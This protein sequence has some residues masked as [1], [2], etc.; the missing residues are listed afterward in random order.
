LRCL[1]L[2]AGLALALAQA[3]S[4]EAG[5]S[6]LNLEDLADGSAT[7]LVQNDA[8]LPADD[9]AAPAAPFNG[10][11]VLSPTEMQIEPA[12]DTREV[13][14]WDAQMFPDVVL[15]FFTY[16]GDLVPSR[17]TSS[18]PTRTRPKTASGR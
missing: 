15:E 2:P 12:L 6:A 17:R 16:E 3:A 7:T 5:R 4:A 8:F 1:L 10:K 14:G 9:S 11:L 18:P 13:M